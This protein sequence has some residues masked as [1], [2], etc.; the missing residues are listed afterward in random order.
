[1]KMNKYLFIILPLIFT[2]S[3]IGH[4][5]GISKNISPLQQ[6][7]KGFENIPSHHSINTTITDLSK[8][9]SDSYM[10]SR[11]MIANKIIDFVLDSD[12]I[13]LIEETGG[14]EIGGYPDYYV[15]SSNKQQVKYFKKQYEYKTYTIDELKA[16]LHQSLVPEL[17]PPHWTKAMIEEMMKGTPFPERDIIFSIQTNSLD[18]C[19]VEIGKLCYTPSTAYDIVIV[20]KADDKYVFQYFSA[21][22]CVQ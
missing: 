16:T 15:Y 8:Q 10:K 22:M 14:F 19:I 9:I 6:I 17:Y 13:I 7:E 4:K 3:C 1:M 20:T 5:T 21:R 18:S 12:T 11:H 2:Y